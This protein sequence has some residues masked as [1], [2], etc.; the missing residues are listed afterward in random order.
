MTKKYK[1]EFAAHRT[2]KAET[3]V[4]FQTRSGERV[5]FDA[6]KPVQRRVRVKFLAKD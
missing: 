4:R 2:V 5:L 6:R 3:P 1:V